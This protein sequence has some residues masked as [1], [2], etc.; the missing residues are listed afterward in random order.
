MTQVRQW[1]TNSEI[2]TDVYASL[3]QEELTR[4][5]P[6]L[7]QSPQLNLRRYLVDWLAIVCENLNID[8]MARHLAV[9]LLDRTM[10]HFTISGETHL[11]RLA[12][13]CLLIATKFE[14]QEVKI[15]KLTNLANQINSDTTAQKEF[16][17]M[18]LLLLDFFNWNVAIPTALHFADYFTMGAIGP[19]DL[20]AGK[21]LTGCNATLYLK[22]YTQYFLEISLQD[23]VFSNCRP[24]LVAAVCIAAS[25]ICLQL[26]PTWTHRL[27]KLTKY[28]WDQIWPY[29]DTMLK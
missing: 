8:S 13:V 6:F 26:S 2:A 22:Q 12:L 5:L 9:Y 24:S 4:C 28:S 10:D 29:I 25:R 3:L 16:F 18:E 21:P 15:A 11:Q 23:H 27:F 20:H 19:N 17:Q 7:G 14:E 1:H